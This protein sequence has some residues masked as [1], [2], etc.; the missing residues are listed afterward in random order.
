MIVNEPFTVNVV[1][2]L[3]AET[4]KVVEG[5]SLTRSDIRLSECVHFWGLY[6]GFDNSDP[7]IFPQRIGL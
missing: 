7:D 4:D 6:G 2:L 3:Q 1:Q 5:L